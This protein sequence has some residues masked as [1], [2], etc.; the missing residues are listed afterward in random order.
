MFMEFSNKLK[1]V[2]L[3]VKALKTGRRRGKKMASAIGDEDG[4]DKD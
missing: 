3:A 4:S 1:Q 2:E